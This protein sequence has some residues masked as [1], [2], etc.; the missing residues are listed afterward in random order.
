MFKK[1]GLG[2][3]GLL[4]I[5]LVII[6]AVAVL[7]GGGDD[8]SGVDTATNDTSSAAPSSS[9]TPTKTTPTK[10]KAPAASNELDADAEVAN[11]VVEGKAY[12]LGDFKIR[13]GWTIRKT[14]FLGYEMKNLVVENTDDSSHMFNVTFKLHTGPGGKRIVDNFSCIAD[15]ANPGDIVDVDCF[16]DA[17]SAKPYKYITVENAF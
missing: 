16:G 11:K 13:K 17:D 4:G 8:N 1:L 10:T 12:Q 15:E 2:C 3:L 6:I 5:L 7:G 9:D 14:D